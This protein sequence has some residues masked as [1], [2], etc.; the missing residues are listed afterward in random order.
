MANH[1]IVDGNSND[2]SEHHIEAVSSLMYI[3]SSID[4]N[5]ALSTGVESGFLEHDSGYLARE[6]SDT[7]SS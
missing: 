6:T 7:L 3:C 4:N 5:H 1:I 2:P